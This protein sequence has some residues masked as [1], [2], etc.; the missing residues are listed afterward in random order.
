MWIQNINLVK[1]AWR[2][3]SILASDDVMLSY[4]KIFKISAQWVGTMVFH[5]SH[6]KFAALGKVL[7]KKSQSIMWILQW[8]VS[9]DSAEWLHVTAQKSTY[10]F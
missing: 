6:D 7:K 1:G 3:P 9:V 10:T 4:L 2:Y 8:K 5:W